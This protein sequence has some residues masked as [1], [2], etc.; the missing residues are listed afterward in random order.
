MQDTGAF[1]YYRGRHD[2]I[3]LQLEMRNTSQ[4]L[5]T[6]VDDM[7]TMDGNIIVDDSGRA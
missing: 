5:K 7:K 6:H 3:E 2:G 4:K 1:G